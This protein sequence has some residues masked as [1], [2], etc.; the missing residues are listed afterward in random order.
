M[1]ILITL[2]SI[3]FGAYITSCQNINS[4]GIY[5]LANNLV[6]SGDC[7][8]VNAQNVVIDGQGY[9]ITSWGH[10]ILINVSSFNIS[11]VNVNI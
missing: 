3:V 10:G 2:I 5:Y 9:S 4:D 1:I 11:I 7:I 6:S 8:I